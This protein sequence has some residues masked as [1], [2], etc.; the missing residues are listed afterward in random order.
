MSVRVDAMAERRLNAHV[1]T[2]ANTPSQQDFF[3]SD[4][5]V[6][7]TKAYIDEEVEGLKPGMTAEVKI[8]VA[9]ALEHVLTVP[10]HAIIGSAELGASRKCYVMTARGPEERAI[11]VG[12][13]SDEKAEI[14]SGLTEGDEI[15]TNP[16]L[17]AGDK[18]KTRE[19][20]ELREQS[21]NGGPEG[22][23]KGGAGGKAGKGEGGVAPPPGG[24]KAG[25]GPGAK[26]MEGPPLQKGGIQMSPEDQEKRRKA[27]DEMR[28]ATPEKRKE[29]LE[30]MPEQ[31]RGH[32]KDS[33]KAAGID[34]KD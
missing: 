29:M 25:P 28:Q 20:G 18:M 33:L 1:E 27:M 17:L 26:G 14:R 13:S 22:G 15:V 2:V 24:P 6:Y 16:K 9:D 7:A 30:K 5:K 23:R 4:V 21:K 3:A 10:L 34:V 31:I 12:I 8:S 11:V 19:P 32:V